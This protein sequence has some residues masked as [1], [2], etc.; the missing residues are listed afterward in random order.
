[1]KT[2]YLTFVIFILSLNSCVRENLL[3]L[4]ED[5]GCIEKIVVPVN[6][7]T[8]GAADIPIVNE[9]FAKNGIDNSKYR[10]Y[11]Y[12]HDSIQTLFPPYT[13]FDSKVVRVDQY[14]NG[15][16]IFFSDMVLNFKNEDINY[17]G[18]HLSKGT[19]LNTSCR[20]TLGQLR[21]LF[22]DAAEHDGYKADQY[23]EAC[24]KAE[25]GYLDLNAGKPA[26]TEN[27]IKA[28]R[29]TPKDSEYPSE[30]PVAYFQDDDG[31]LISYDNGIR[32]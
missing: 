15:L 11:Q 2:N 3:P 7:H 22:N 8:I 16:R 27:L 25:F 18:G 26:Y 28:W 30:Y 21:K 24:L 1:M 10:Y 9:L 5:N 23:K 32:F 17:I 20:L 12:S 13:K 29:I 31:K 6:A 19:T 14:A 4:Q